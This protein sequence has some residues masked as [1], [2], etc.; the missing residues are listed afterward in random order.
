M[1]HSLDPLDFLP[2]AAYVDEVDDD[3]AVR[4]SSSSARYEELT[5]IAPRDL[6]EDARS[7]DERIHPG[8]CAAYAASF[9]RLWRRQQDQDLTYRL[10]H[11][12]GSW[13]WLHDR[14]AAVRDDERGITVIHGFLVDETRRC[15]A[16]AAAA[17]ALDTLE[18]TVAVRTRE[19]EESLRRLEETEAGLEKAQALSHTG[20]F[21]WIAATGEMRGSAELARIYGVAADRTFDIDACLS[22]I[23]P[24]DSAEL[25]AALER[26]AAGGPCPHLGHRIVRDGET[27]DVEVDFAVT[28]GPD[29]A[30]RRVH[31]SVQDVTE[32]RRA[33][34][35]SG[36]HTELL[37]LLADVSARFIALPA[38][39][40]DEAVE[41]VL[42]EVGS[43]VGADRAYVFRSDAAAETVSNTHEWCAEGVTPMRTRLQALPRSR[44]SWWMDQLDAD[45]VIRLDDIGVLPPSAAPERTALE[46]QEIKSILVVPMR[47]SERGIGY[48]GLDAV[49]HPQTW[50]DETVYLLRTVADALAGALQRKLI[51]AALRESE[52][53]YRTLSDS[54]TDIIVVANRAGTV[55]HANPAACAALQRPE[56]LGGSPFVELY[57]E[58]ARRKISAIAAD[59]VDGGCAVSFLPLMRGDAATVPVETRLWPADWDGETCVFAVSRDLSKEHEALQLFDRIFHRSPVLM[60]V[61]RLP[62]LR[63]VD[64]NDAFLATLG[65]ERDEVVGHSL[66]E[67]DAFP[68]IADLSRAAQRLTKSGGTRGVELRVKTKAGRVLDGVF[69]AETVEGADGRYLLS[70]MV[71]V[72]AQKQ[73]EREIQILNRQLERRVAL[74]TQQLESA[75]KELRGFVDSVAHDLRGPLRTIGSFGQI[76]QMEQ[77]DRLD[78]DGRD[79]VDRIV[80]ANARM[81]RLIDALL[82]LS[83]LTYLPLHAEPVDITGLVVTVL[84]ELAEGDPERRVVWTVAEGMTAVADPDLTRILLENLLGN[85]W[86]FTSQNEVAHIEVG[87]GE[88]D[89]ETAY[90]VRDDGAGFDPAY[91]SRLFVAFER[92]HD[93]TEFPGVG[94]G[95]ATVQRIVERHGGRVWAESRPGKGACFSFTLPPEPLKARRRGVPPTRG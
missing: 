42:G 74:R 32:Q 84:E 36:R 10:R 22:R 50:S 41:T 73:A 24:E 29:G 54:S 4:L 75:N 79:A 70:V 76:L 39:D 62:D 35:E 40:V 91:A 88:R 21:E 58:P 1:S 83:G 53:N 60:A 47:T 25:L 80:R 28:K 52:A 72:T 55:V 20:S 87:V 92:L 18:E 37:R 5:G 8:D 57:D 31:G 81:A 63:F 12:D 13:V 64:V 95:L 17:A 51:E 69:A 61:N 33:E 56:G 66:L 45:E 65:Y 11:D 59:V 77:A 19:L 7:W 44:F 2:I 27:R 26:L 85:A 43:F 94:I 71:D 46:A 89:G 6:A 14:A 68:E 86:K 67:L 16:E 15:E 9:D 90:V 93:E 30:V 78:E 3:G 38:R 82:D 23:H 34:R 48:L 49:G